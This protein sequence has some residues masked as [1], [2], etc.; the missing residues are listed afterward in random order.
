MD[1]RPTAHPQ[2]PGNEHGPVPESVH[3]RTEDQGPRQD[4]QA[5]HGHERSCG[6][7]RHAVPGDHRQ[8]H[9]A[10]GR[11]RHPE[12]QH[13]QAGRGEHGALAGHCGAPCRA[14]RSASSPVP[15]RHASG[16]SVLTH[17]ATRAKLIGCAHCA[18]LRDDPIELPRRRSEQPAPQHDHLGVEQAHQV[19]DRHPPALHGVGHHP[20]RHDVPRRQRV[21]DFVGRDPLRRERAQH[22]LVLRHRLEHRPRHPR[23]PRPEACDSNPPQRP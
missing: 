8:Q 20:L 13:P 21:E 9:R 23:D 1:A 12:Q 3:H 4:P 14:A 5:H 16:P 6:G 18:R 7:L 10:Q 19:G 2:R 17:T 15:S 11:Q 22:P